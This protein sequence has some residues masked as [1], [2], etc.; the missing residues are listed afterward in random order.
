MSKGKAKIASK[1]NPEGRG[2]ASEYTIDGKKIVPVKLITTT[3]TFLSA[4]FDGTGSPILDDSG[5]PLTWKEA[6][7]RC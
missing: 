4:E 7:S 1:N 2:R 3:R 6:K 5:R